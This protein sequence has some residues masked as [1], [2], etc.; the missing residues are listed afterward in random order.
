MTLKA[1]VKAYFSKAPCFFVWGADDTQAVSQGSA[2]L[3]CKTD[4]AATLAV[5]MPLNNDRI[6]RYNATLLDL[7]LSVAGWNAGSQ[8]LARCL[9]DAVKKPKGDTY[10]VRY[11]GIKCSLII[12]RAHALTTLSVEVVE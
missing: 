5:M 3:Q 11:N 2:V 12:D 1:N 7:L 10:E 4:H 9:R 8:W 6:V